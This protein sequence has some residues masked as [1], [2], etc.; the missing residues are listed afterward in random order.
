MSFLQNIFVIIPK[1]AI[2]STFLIMEGDSYA[3]QHFKHAIQAF[4]MSKASNNYIQLHTDLPELGDWESVVD[5]PL[6]FLHV[7]F[8]CFPHKPRFPK[9]LQGNKTF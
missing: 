6:S 9:K 3:S 7:T 2:I 8:I 1:S 5:P 4:P